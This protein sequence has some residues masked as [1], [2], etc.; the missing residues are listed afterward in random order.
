MNRARPVER[1]LEDVELDREVAVA[2]PHHAAGDEPLDLE[3]GFLAELAARRVDGPLPAF[4]LAARELPEPAEEPGR[5]APL[6]EPSRPR[7][8]DRER[9]PHVGP[10]R[11]RRAAR[12]RTGVAGLP[13]RPAVTAQRATRAERCR[14]PAD[15]LT[16]FHEPLVERGRPPG[17]NRGRERGGEPGA[18]AGAPNVPGLERAS[19]GDAEAVRLERDHRRVER[20]ARDRPG[21]IR[22]DARQRLELRHRRR[23]PAA[24]LAREL[25]GGGVEVPGAGVVPRSLPDLEDV[26]E[27]GAGERVERREPRDEPI[28]VRRGL[29]DPRLL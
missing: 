23:E 21:D 7:A 22:A 13:V 16:E 1:P 20:E 11:G 14:G 3:P 26:P 24:P 19:G 18:H 15:R 9:A 27:R 8:H 12:Q 6:D 5:S 28:E 4:D 10:A 29:R 25:A 17:R 2:V